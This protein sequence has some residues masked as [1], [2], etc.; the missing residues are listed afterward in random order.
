MDA[1]KDS[2][3]TLEQANAEKLKRRNDFIKKAS[4]SVQEFGSPVVYFK[5]GMVMR[6][7]RAERNITFKREPEVDQNGKRRQECNGVKVNL[8][9][10]TEALNEFINELVDGWSYFGFELDD[11]SKVAKIVKGQERLVRNRNHLQFNFREREEGETEK[12]YNSYL[13]GFYAY[14]LRKFETAFGE[15]TKVDDC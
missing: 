2:K 3:K 11:S 5:H 4:D 14:D 6:L 10:E 1:L 9:N 15:I 13:D 12:E 7:N 8:Y